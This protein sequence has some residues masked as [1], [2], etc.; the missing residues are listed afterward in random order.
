MPEHDLN[1]Y[2]DLKLS[3]EIL[4]KINSG[5]CSS[6]AIKVGGIPSFENK[7]IVNMSESEFSHV[8]DLKKAENNLKKYTDRIKLSNYGTAEGGRISLSRQDLE[9]I[10]L[11][12][13]PLV[14]VGI[15]NGGA[16]TSY[17]DRLKNRS[18]SPEIYDS[19]RI[20][21]DALREIHKDSPKGITPAYINA[22]G[23][24]GASFIELKMRSFLLK[25]ARYRK[26]TGEKGFSFPMFQ[27]TSMQTDRALAEEYIRYRESIYLQDLIEETDTDITSVLTEVQTLISA[28]THSSEGKIQKF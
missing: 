13:L 17:T 22:D 8:F 23:T 10:G 5:S 12:L 4:E 24:D 11:Y 14:S 27:M 21:F 9:N 18:F 3:N 28:F 16:A 19:C 26:L 15:L 20:Q 1:N 7:S 2:F 6:S 25:I